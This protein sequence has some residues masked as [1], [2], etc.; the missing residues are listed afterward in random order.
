MLGLTRRELETE[1]RDGLRHRQRA[2]AVGNCYSPIPKATAPVLD[3][4]CEGVGVK[5]PRATRPLIHTLLGFNLAQYAESMRKRSR[6][7]AR[8]LKNK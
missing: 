4:T 3:P 7:P 6:N 5:F 1:L 2:K 8:S